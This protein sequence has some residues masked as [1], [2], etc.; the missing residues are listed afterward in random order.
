MKK[1]QRRILIIHGRR[2]YDALIGPGRVRRAAPHPM[3]LRSAPSVTVSRPMPLLDQRDD[4]LWSNRDRLA[5]PRTLPL[6]AKSESRHQGAKTPRKS[7]YPQITQI[8]QIYDFRCAGFVPRPA[9][10]ATS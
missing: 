7:F 9:P 3:P 5:L 4:I 2:F 6:R 1:P 8:T 10:Q